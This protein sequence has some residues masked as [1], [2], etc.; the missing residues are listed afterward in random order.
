MADAPNAQINNQLGQAP[1][2]MPSQAPRMPSQTPSILSQPAI[3]TNMQIFKNAIGSPN[4]NFN[5]LFSQQMP[6]Y[7]SNSSSG[8]APVKQYSP[9]IIPSMAGDAQASGAIIGGKQY[10]K[11]NYSQPSYTVANNLAV[12][13]GSALPAGQ[14][15]Y[16]KNKDGSYSSVTKAQQAGSSRAGYKSPTYYTYNPPAL[17]GHSAVNN[18]GGIQNLPSLPLPA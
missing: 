7:G 11:A 10:T 2:N 9:A 1:T 4:A 3:N 16:I 8:Y 17:I 5:N 6:Q 15:Y 18:G 12:R 14:T 13:L